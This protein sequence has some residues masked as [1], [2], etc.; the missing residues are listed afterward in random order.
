MKKKEWLF[1]IMSEDQESCNLFRVGLISFLLLIT[2]SLVGG[3]S[4]GTDKQVLL[5]LKTFLEGQNRV[6]RGSKYT[7]WNSTD[8]SP[9][10]WPGISCDGVGN[11]VT[12]VN[13][14]GDNLAGKIFDNFSALTGLTYLDL[15][16]NTLENAVPADLGTCRS[17]RFLNLSHN[18]IDGELNLTGLY[19]LEIL[20]LSMNR[21]GGEIWPVFPGICNNLVVMN[22]SNNGF[23]GEIGNAFAR[24]SNL[25]YLDLSTNNLSGGLPFGIDKLRGFSVGQNN[26]SGELPSWIFRQNCSLQ[27][28]DLSENKF[29]GELPKEISYC[30]D[31]SMLNLW[32][33]SFSGLIPEEIGFIQGLETLYL[34]NNKFS[35]S[36]PD[37]LSG[38]K[39]LLYLD[40]SKNGFGGEIQEIFGR[41]TQVKF[42]LLNGN[43]YT[44]GII[45]SG[46]P[47]LANLSRLDLSENSFSGPL[48]AEI[49]QMTNLKFLILAF[50]HF[51]GTIPS[52]YGSFPVI[53]ALDLS[54]NSLSGS[55]PQ[56]LGRL[57]SL[58]WL[59]L[60]SNSLTGEIPGEL[61]NCSSLLWLNLE[62]N[63]LSGS[64]PAEL[65]NIGSNPMPTFLLNR[66]EDKIIPSSS[67]ECQIMKRWIPAD[68]PPFSFVYP[69]LTGKKCR[70]L[71]DKLLKG[72]GLFQFCGAGINVRTFQ[73]SG[74]VQLCNNKLSGLVPPE[75]GKM[76]SFSMLHIG[77]NNFHGKFPSEIGKMPLV[78]LNVT[79]NKFSGQIPPQIGNMKC[80]LNLDLSHNNF[81][82]QFP[83]S[84]NNLTDLN[85]F[86]ISYNPYIYGVIP[87][88]GQLATFEKSS[89]LGDP[90]LN[91]PSFIDNSTENQ[92]DKHE[93][94]KK[95][96]NLGT[97]LVFAALVLAFIVCGVIFFVVCLVVKETSEKSPADYLLEDTKIRHDSS[98]PD[99]SSSP[100][101]PSAV[102]VIRLDKKF[103]THS[104]IVNATGNFSADRIVGRGGFGT[105][106]RGVLPDGREVAVKKLQREGIEG[107]REFMAEMEVLSGNG[108]GWPHPN[109]VTLYGWCLDGS[110]KLLVYEF[111]GG[112]SL[113]DMITDR[114]KF[115]WKKRIKAAIDVAKAL[116]FLHHECHPCIVHR[117]VKASN[118]LLDRDGGARVTDFG[119]A[120][121]M[122]SSKTHVST[123]MAGTVGY[124]APEYGQTWQATTRGDVYSYGVLAM[125]LATGRRAVDGGEECLLEWARRVMGD[126]RQGF[127]SRGV[128]PVALLVS[129]LADGAEEM[130]ELLRIGIRCTAETPCLRPNMKEVLNM[131]LR[132]KFADHHHGS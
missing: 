78:V 84:L 19:S 40:L 106:Y 94:P 30:K 87:P 114:V 5:S 28:L 90:L 12:G 23:S 92:P 103:F 41:F 102:K 86:N 109:L 58:L 64:I 42:L 1:E 112:G 35:S 117:D 47:N 17:L 26:I 14:S 97:F 118:V 8:E 51:T 116:V 120:R 95:T 74:Y 107:E 76:Q 55:I 52:E 7:L 81:S 129:G 45:S 104:D 46:I 125:E 53:Q 127:S 126:G 123:M 122:D 91:L 25:E 73:I 68:Y 124:V 6:N 93:N 9:C 20:D 37:T 10:K 132:I 72:Y 2:G 85:K 29:S 70:S 79:Q 38:L 82:G 113:E 131:L 61:G 88:I 130:C 22:I 69:L 115:S 11:R 111:M 50:N 77:Y 65:A 101:F 34:G 75:I 100:W 13:L 67:G 18:I 21:L 80:L 15:S 108:F 98:S 105:V 83:T 128:I 54:F 89:F 57:A 27:A 56:S 99:G 66:D 62:N 44:G 96:T 36:I 59:T 16:K 110:E 121:F 3:D 24:C 49:S 43:A 39:N 33:N 63:R 71:W 60:A 119:L 31:L 48:P 4:L 32:G